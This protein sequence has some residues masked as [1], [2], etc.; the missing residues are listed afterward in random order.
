MLVFLLLIFPI[1]AYAFQGNVP[2]PQEPAVKPSPLQPPEPVAT[3]QQVSE[4]KE[5]IQQL[6]RRVTELE[7]Q[8]QQLKKQQA[9]P[10]EIVTAGKQPEAR[11]EL[12]N[13]PAAETQDETTTRE[14]IAASYVPHMQIRGF[15]DVG[16]HVSRANGTT[17]SFGLGQMDLLI[18]SRLSERVSVLGELVF[19]SGEDNE[20]GVDLE[21]ILLQY[22]PSDSFN[23]AVGRYHT[24][25]GYYNTAY[26]HGTYFQT[27][28]GRPFIF[29]FEDEGGVLPSHNVGMTINGRVPSGGLGLHYVAEIGNGRAYQSARSGAVQNTFDTDGGKAVNLGAF[30]RPD[31]LI[32]FQAG[33]SYY[34]D[35]FTPDGQSKIGQTILAAHAVYQRPDFE[36]LN[37]ALLIRHTPRGG[38]RT[39]NTSAFYTQ[40]AHRFRKYR[41][42]FRY[43]YFNAPDS[44][45]V[46]GD[47]GLRHGPSLGLRVDVND[48]AAFK[49]QYDHLRQRRQRAINSLMAQFAFTF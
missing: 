8:V 22:S 32:G 26:H 19:E 31:K 11:T 40:I 16:A 33:F 17:S 10:V 30:I 48:F 1:T 20:M 46:I 24:A 25:I 39:W 9:A 13:P 15:A 7:T 2:A 49:L 41:P 44:D 38:S 47:A 43:Q 28:T 18:N 29:E 5:L 36:F 42:F 14:A 4:E 6:L 27:A 37:E 34:R 21:R 12:G 23:L 35:R 3:P 45:P